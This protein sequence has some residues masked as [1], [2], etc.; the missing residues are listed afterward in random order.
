M[1][2]VGYELS[3]S[4]RSRVGMAV[5]RRVDYIVKKARSVKNNT[6]RQGKRSQYWCQVALHPDEITQMPGDIIHQL[7]RENEELISENQELRN[8][9][10]GTKIIEHC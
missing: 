8:E 6:T 5:Y 7:K 2:K 9:M 1:V 4:A 10:E 3:S